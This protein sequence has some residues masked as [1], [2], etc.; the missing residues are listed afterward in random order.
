MEKLQEY[1]QIEL[2]L[3]SVYEDRY[4][5]MK[6]DLILLKSELGMYERGNPINEEDFLLEMGEKTESEIR[7]KMR[8]YFSSFEGRII[9]NGMMIEDLCDFTIKM[10]NKCSASITTN[11]FSSKQMHIHVSI[12]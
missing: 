5:P 6:S 10:E 3:S 12:W 11:I 2:G 9:N 7:K 1:L 8:Q 4:S